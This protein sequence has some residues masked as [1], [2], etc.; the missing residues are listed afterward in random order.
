LNETRK[1]KNE[2]SSYY[3]KKSGGANLFELLQMKRAKE[4]GKDLRNDVAG[5]AMDVVLTTMKI[6]EKSD[7]DI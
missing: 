6:N 1:D 4:N 3:C 2:T 5:T 7:I